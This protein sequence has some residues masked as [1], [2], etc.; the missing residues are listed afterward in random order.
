[1][2][3]YYS[4]VDSLT[5]KQKRFCEKND[6]DMND[7]DKKTL[8]ATMRENDREQWRQYSK[9]YYATHTEQ[10]K[11]AMQ[12]HRALHREEILEK[13]KT[14]AQQDIVCECGCTVRR[15]NLSTHLKT[16]KHKKQIAII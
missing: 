7:I 14:Y 15:N 1:M 6:M 11:T 9:Q 10:I 8:I 16:E 2:I 3:I 13:K 12:Q 5:L 4:M